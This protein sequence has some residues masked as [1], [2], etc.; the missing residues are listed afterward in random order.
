MNITDPIA[1]MLTR[2]RN[3]SSGGL[4]YAV[5]PASGQKIEITKILESEGFIRGFR[6][7]RDGRQGKIK[8]A[9]KYTMAGEPVIQGIRRVST[10]GC[11]RYATVESLSRRHARGIAVISTSKGMMTDSGAKAQNVGGELIAY[12]W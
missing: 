7:V 3:A 8:I 5:I 4:K 2:I 1:D 11:R 12:V 6:L 9:L 10:P